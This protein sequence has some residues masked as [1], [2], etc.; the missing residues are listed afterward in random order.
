M[1]K[2]QREP[3]PATVVIP[4][5]PDPKPSGKGFFGRI[6]GLFGAIFR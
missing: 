3:L 6:K 5:A 1:A 4:P 2:E